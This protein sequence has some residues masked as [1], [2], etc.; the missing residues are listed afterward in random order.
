MLEDARARGIAHFDTAWVYTDGR[1]EEILGKLI[2]PVREEV[3]V[4]TKVG[5]SGGAG[6]D[7]LV[8]Q[9]EQSRQRLALDQVD[10]LYLHRFDPA[11]DLR[12]TIETFAQFQS[13]GQI[14]HIG[15]SNFAAWQVMKAQAIAAE[16]G[17][18]ID[19]VQPMYN[20]VKRQAEVEILPMCADQ[21]IAACTY[22]PL[23]G[24]LLTGKYAEGGTGRLTEDERY[25]S[26]YGQ[27][28][29]QDAAAGLAALARREGLH[30]ATLAVAWVA[31]GPFGAQPIL[32][33]R[34]RAQLAPS[35]AALDLTLAA[36][37]L[38]GD[39]ESLMPA[40]AAATDRTEE[41]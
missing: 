3:F 15:L 4:A 37:A 29:M 39:V 10:L 11:T 22:S 18:R 16:F 26:R 23:G 30:P 28:A 35:L 31:A 6:R 41:T 7:N 5:Y 21:D 8:A 34:S 12:E 2:A 24:G 27:K 9:F 19:A 40:P 33:A 20:L 38:R 25:A 36:G 13:A 17:T 1:A 32:S 14:R